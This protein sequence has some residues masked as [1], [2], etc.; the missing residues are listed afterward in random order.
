MNREYVLYAIIYPVDISRS[1]CYTYNI[2]NTA[3]T[4]YFTTTLRYYPD[5]QIS[6]TS[7]GL[8]LVSVVRGCVLMGSRAHIKPNKGSRSRDDQK[9]L[10]KVSD[11]SAVLQTSVKPC[12]GPRS[13]KFAICVQTVK[14]RHTGKGEGGG[15]SKLKGRQTK[16]YGR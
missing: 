1:I 10:K 15:V 6:T 9:L 12:Q 11:Q 7:S 16:V 5:R 4:T 2:C 13:N 14:S 3:N 8:C